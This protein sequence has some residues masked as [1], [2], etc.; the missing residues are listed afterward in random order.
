[1]LAKGPWLENVPT[2]VYAVDFSFI[3][4]G[5]FKISVEKSNHPF[6]NSKSPCLFLFLEFT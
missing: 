2:S 4:T 3:N 1:V 6:L 5:A